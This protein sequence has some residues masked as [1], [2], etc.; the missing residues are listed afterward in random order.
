VTGATHADGLQKIVVLNPKGGCGKTT[1]ATNLA[2]LY[3][4]RGPPPTLVD[5]DPQGFSTRWLEKRPAHRPPIHGLRLDGAAFS[6]AAPLVPRAHAESRTVIVDLPAA[7][8]HEQLHAY[9]YLADQVLLPI[10]PSDIDIYAATRFIAELLLDVQL[11]RREQKLA[12]VANR[13]RS[14]TKSYQALMR[15]LGSLKIPLIASLRD[16]QNYVQ[17]SSLGIGVCELPAYRAEADVAALGAIVGWL[18]RRQLAAK[19]RATMIADAAYRRAAERGFAG[20][21]P[22]E[23]WLAA[24]RQVDAVLAEP[25]ADRH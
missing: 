2:S 17:A 5:G 6:A 4:V 19:Q 1:L 18:D 9:T 14:H 10:L 7:V 22:L 8:P 13:V 21:D 20:G 11:D 12:I 23:D 15:F 3:A 24:E 16:S 25:P